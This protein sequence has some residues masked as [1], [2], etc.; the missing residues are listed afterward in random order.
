[1]RTEAIWA[2]GPELD[3]VFTRSQQSLH[4]LANHVISGIFSDLEECVTF[5]DT[6]K[7]HNRAELLD[8]LSSKN[9]VRRDIQIENSN[10]VTNTAANALFLRL[11]LGMDRDQWRQRD[12]NSKQSLSYPCD[13][14]LHQ[15]HNGGRLIN[16]QP[17]C[18]WLEANEPRINQPQRTK[19]MKDFSGEQPMENFYL[20]S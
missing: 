7:L 8:F 15:N 19:G 9:R 20:I 5:T 4:A 11:G 6:V 18:Q 14:G 3:M 1:M 12:Q 10:S 17:R 2:D 13:L 16:D